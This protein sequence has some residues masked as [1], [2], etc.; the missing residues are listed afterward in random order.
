MH[1]TGGDTVQPKTIYGTEA[2][3]YCTVVDMSYIVK[4]IKQI[5]LCVLLWFHAYA[6]GPLHLLDDL[7]KK[8]HKYVSIVTRRA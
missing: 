3:K 8:A 2:S 6:A 7:H 1:T 5:V 4:I